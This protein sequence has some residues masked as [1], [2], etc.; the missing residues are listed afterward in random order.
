M[1][2]A[3]E[4]GWPLLRCPVGGDDTHTFGPTLCM[5]DEP[6]DRVDL[7]VIVA[8]VDAEEDSELSLCSICEEIWKLTFDYVSNGV[9]AVQFEGI[10]IANKEQLHFPARGSWRASC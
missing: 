6:V 2:L 10:L 4:A 1:L 3:L 7:V 9:E 8:P 5:E